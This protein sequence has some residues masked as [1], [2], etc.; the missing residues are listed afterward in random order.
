MKYL[1]EQIAD[2]RAPAKGNEIE[3]T[4]NVQDDLPGQRLER[5]HL[6]HPAHVVPIDNPFFDVVAFRLF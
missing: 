3:E 6:I 5:V 4:E 1:S 2:L